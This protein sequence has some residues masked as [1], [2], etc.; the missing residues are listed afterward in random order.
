MTR[1]TLPSAFAHLAIGIPD[2]QTD[3][4]HLFREH[5]L[6]TCVRRLVPDNGPLIVSSPS[7]LSRRFKEHLQVAMR[8][9]RK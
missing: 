4:S 2:L 5:T 6:A 9:A 1:V 7:L 3:K 8:G